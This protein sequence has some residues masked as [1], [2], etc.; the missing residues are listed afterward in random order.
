M[1]LF[2]PFVVTRALDEIR[3]NFIG[4]LLA[5]VEGDVQTARFALFAAFGHVEIAGFRH[6][7]PVRFDFFAV[8]QGEIG[9]V[10]RQDFAFQGIAGGAR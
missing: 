9:L 1:V 8:T 3:T 10:E 4:I 2:R 5:T 7:N 6:R